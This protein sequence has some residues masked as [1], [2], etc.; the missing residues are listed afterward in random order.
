M[1]VDMLEGMTA[2]PEALPIIFVGEIVVTFG[3]RGFIF[4]FLTPSGI[5]RPG[6]RN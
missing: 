5:Q 6:I 1:E 3:R 4:G 2:V